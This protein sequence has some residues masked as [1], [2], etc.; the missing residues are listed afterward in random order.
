MICDQTV[1]DITNETQ[2]DD[3]G[4]QYFQHDSVKRAEKIWKI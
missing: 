3:Q 2:I 1:S 4:Y